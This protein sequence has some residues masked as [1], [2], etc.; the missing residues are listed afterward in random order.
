MGLK[1]KAIA[2]VV[3][4]VFLNAVTN[5]VFASGMAADQ[6][7]NPSI[8]GGQNV[9]NANQAMSEITVSGG[10]AY[11]LFAL[12]TSV[13]GPIRTVMGL[14]F[15]GEIMFISLGVPGWLVAFLFAPKYFVFGG[16]I[17][18]ALAGRRF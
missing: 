14:L 17:I 7:I 1:D 3:F 13:T 16:T 11:T 5:L 15:G 18:Y 9:D 4:L 12:Y 6:G 8:S 2:I 10:F